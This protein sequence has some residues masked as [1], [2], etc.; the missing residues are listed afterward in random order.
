MVPVDRDEYRRW[1]GQAWHTLAS[2]RRDA[3]ASDYDW[4][5]FKAQQ[6]A[7]Y[8]LEGLLR[9]LGHLAPGHSLLRLLDAVEQHARI[10]VPEPIR[11]A[12]RALDRHY[13]P[14]RYPDAYPAGMPY[15]FYDRPTA[16]AALSAAEQVV[17]FVREHAVKLGLEARD[18]GGSG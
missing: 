13:I 3:A 16:D 12:A 11:Q 17:E 2:A 5:C 14:P 18:E 7:E 10:P 6:A 1:L 8:S 9:G 4:A 15:E